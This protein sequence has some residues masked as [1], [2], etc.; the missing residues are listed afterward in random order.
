MGGRERPRIDGRSRG[1]R[2]HG[3]DATRNDVLQSRDRWTGEGPDRPGDRCA[4]WCDGADRRC[5]GHHVQDA[6]HQPRCGGA[7]SAMP[8]RQ[9]G[10]SPRI[11]AAD[12]GTSVDRRG[13]GNRRRLSHRRTR[14][15]ASHRGRPTSRRFRIGGLGRDRIPLASGPPESGGGR[16][17]FR[18][19]GAHHRDVHAGVDARGRP[20]VGRR[21]DRGGQRRRD[22]GDA[23]GSRIRTR[24]AEDGNATSTFEG[25]DRLGRSAA[26]GR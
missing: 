11:P 13:R 8:E 17:S 3:S 12:R 1:P 7:R 15:N 14:W 6:E 10:V 9:G 23:A 25:H 24:P 22:R 5:H 26:A 20:T 4:G 19:G 16:T 21:A 18:R 2:D